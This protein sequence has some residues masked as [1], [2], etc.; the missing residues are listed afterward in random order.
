MSHHHFTLDERMFIQIA[1]ESNK[2]HREIA[3][4][5]NVSH[6]AINYEVSKRSVVL[7]FTPTRR[8]NKPT[9]LSLDLRTRRGCGLV[10]EKLAAQGRWK[11]RLERFSRGQPSYD[12]CS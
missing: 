10:P 11:K 9:I 12:A 7:G 5:L 2:S 4:E 8:V 3:R 1:K 6:S